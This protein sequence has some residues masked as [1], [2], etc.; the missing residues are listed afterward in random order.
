MRSRLR[1]IWLFFSEENGR[2][3]QTIHTTPLVCIF[4]DKSDDGVVLV[5]KVSDFGSDV[6]GSYVMEVIV[7]VMVIDLMHLKIESSVSN[8]KSQLAA[9]CCEFIKKK[10]QPPILLILTFSNVNSIDHFYLSIR[11]KKYLVSVFVSI[12]YVFISFMFSSVF[13][14][15]FYYEILFDLILNISWDVYLL[16]WL[17]HFENIN[18]CFLPIRQKRQETAIM[19]ATHHI[20]HSSEDMNLSVDQR[21]SILLKTFKWMFFAPLACLGLP[22]ASILVHTQL[23]ALFAYWT[24]SCV[25]PRLG[26]VLGAVGDAIE[27][28]FVTP[29]HHRVH[30]ACNRYCLDKNYGRV[31]ILW[32]RIFGT[33]AEEREDEELVFGSLHQ[34]ATD[35]IVGVQVHPFVELVEKFRSMDNFGDK[36]RALFY[37]PGWFPGTPRLGNPEDVPD[38][39]GR[40]KHNAALPNW[41][42]KVCLQI[43]YIGVHFLLMDMNELEKHILPAYIL[44]QAMSL[45]GLYDGHHYAAFLEPLRLTISFA[46]LQFFPLHATDGQATLAAIVNGV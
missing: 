25:V 2:E 31:L 32:D 43:I 34:P 8:S 5:V 15:M 19:W 44:L 22:P 40:A 1:K 27:F 10:K 11:L 23:G 36:V 24:H 35:H 28:I 4:G 45:G 7:V 29:S 17:L 21:L 9:K 6:V 46:I 16:S 39:R 12:F 42:N 14:T 30:H 20:H 3:V 18:V 33:Y 13:F 38:V 41:I 37:G 26:K